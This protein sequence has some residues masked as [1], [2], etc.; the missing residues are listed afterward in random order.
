VWDYIIYSVLFIFGTILA[1]YLCS[2]IFEGVR[3][4]LQLLFE[5]VLFL[6]IVNYLLFTT[7]SSTN[8]V[9]IGFLYFFFSFL[10]M[11]FS[12]V[13]GFLVFGRIISKVFFKNNE[14]SKSTIKL[15]KSLR[16]KI[17][18]KQL[19]QHFESSGFSKDLVDHLRKVLKE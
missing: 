13:I 6:I 5:I 4:A 7:V 1:D 9:I 14:Y 3:K 8:P 18:K 12:R 16:S 10:S 19:L 11:I 17:S 15:A 2:L